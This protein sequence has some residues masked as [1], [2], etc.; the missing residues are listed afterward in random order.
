MI[1]EHI[2]AT[3]IVGKSIAMRLSTTFFQ[4]TEYH[5]NAFTKFESKKMDE[6]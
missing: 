1:S 3:T 5:K 6:N 4:K 2:L